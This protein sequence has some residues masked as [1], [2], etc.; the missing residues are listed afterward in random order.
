MIA[1]LS[2]S[3][4]IDVDWAG[5]VNDR[6]SATGYCFSAGSA[7]VSWCTMKQATVALSSAE[8]EYVAASMAMQECV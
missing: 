6:H 2:L 5:D 4:F 8:A 7:V 3:G 1:F